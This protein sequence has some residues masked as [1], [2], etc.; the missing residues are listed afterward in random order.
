MLFMITTSIGRD[1]KP[2]HSG[3]T[4]HVVTSKTTKFTIPLGPVKLFNLKFKKKK[5]KDPMIRKQERTD[6][7]LQKCCFKPF[8]V[9]H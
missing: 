1:G 7:F 9:N 8:G 5:L 2:F 3:K 6:Y 4:R